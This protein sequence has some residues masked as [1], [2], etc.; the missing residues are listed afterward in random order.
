MLATRAAAHGPI[1]DRDQMWQFAGTLRRMNA[2]RPLEVFLARVTA[3]V[4]LDDPYAVA[5]LLLVLHDSGADEHVSALLATDPA[6]RVA[7]ADL[8]AVA[9]LLHALEDTA[10]AGQV[11]AL[12]ERAWLC[13]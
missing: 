9:T 11:Q 7:L 2:N 1:N 5:W 8:M 13:R 3:E 12:A 6:A 4:D 10:A